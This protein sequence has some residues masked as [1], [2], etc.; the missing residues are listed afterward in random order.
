M[1]ILVNSITLVCIAFDRYMAVV[2]VIKSSW[3]PK[4]LYCLIG[5]VCI[6]MCGAGIASPMLAAYN[7]VDITVAET[8]PNNRTVGIKKYPA[9]ICVNDKVR[10]A[11]CRK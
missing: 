9:Q 11:L 8:D 6:W 1:A 2:Q 4:A 7:I 10:N 3:E 5:T